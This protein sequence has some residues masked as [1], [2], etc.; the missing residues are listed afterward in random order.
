[1]V[2]SKLEHHGVE[3]TDVADVLHGFVMPAALTLFELRVAAH[4]LLH[5][6]NR[7]LLRCGRVGRISVHVL[8]FLAGHHFQKRKDEFLVARED[9]ARF[10]LICLAEREVR[11]VPRLGGLVGVHFD[12]VL[13]QVGRGDYIGILEVY[14]VKRK[15]IGNK[16][17]FIV[18]DLTSQ[19]T[20]TAKQRNLPGFVAI[21]DRVGAAHVEVAVFLHQIDDNIH[22]CTS[23]VGVFCN[24]ATDAVAD[25]AVV[26]LLVLFDC[27]VAVVGD[28]DYPLFH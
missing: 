22:A 28:N 4:K 15:R 7:V 2:R 11:I 13:D 23:G 14:L 27:N 26:D 8:V 6:F 1:M 19:V 18:A 10:G 12:G 24:D 20:V 5:I 21:G 25:A 9:T 3:H 16:S 17:D